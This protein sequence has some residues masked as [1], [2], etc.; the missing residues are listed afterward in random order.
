MHVKGRGDRLSKT[1]K[2]EEFGV[3]K[4]LENIL[5][6]WSKGENGGEEAGKVGKRQKYDEALK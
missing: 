4:G 5:S 2:I 3:F 6:N 1:S